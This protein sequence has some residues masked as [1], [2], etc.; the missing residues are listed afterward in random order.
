MKYSLL[1]IGIAMALLSG[2]STDNS[3]SS[4][5]FVS[6]AIESLP[7]VAS[8]AGRRSVLTDP[9]NADDY[10]SL[11]QFFKRQCFMPGSDDFCTPGTITTGDDNDPLKFTTDTLLGF[12]YHAEMYAGSQQTSCDGSAGTI[13]V[14]LF[15]AHTPPDRAATKFLLNYY[16]LL[17]CVSQ[18]SWAT[19]GTVYSAYSTDPAGAYQATLTTRHRVPYEGDDDPGQND[20]FQVYVSNEGTQPKL[21]AFNFA[22]ACSMAARV[23]LLANLIDHKFVVKYIKPQYD[24]GSGLAGTTQVVTAIGVGG[25]NRTTGVPHTGYYFAKF[26]NSRSRTPT[27]DEKCFDNAASNAIVDTS[28]C[29]TAGLPTS[30]ETWTRTAITTYLDISESDQTRL[31]AWLAGLETYDVLEAPDDVPVA[32]GE[33]DTNF[34]KTITVQ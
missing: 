5:S 7:A 29:T 25:L 22:T 24:S 19:E 17:T 14:D 21:L 16:D 3:G 9:T 1:A 12:I 31:D 4:I 10:D 20:F 13:T 32:I 26:T 30:S 6:A 11:R 28:V 23:I 15:A 8:G 34:P 2:C 33:R 18:P 27:T